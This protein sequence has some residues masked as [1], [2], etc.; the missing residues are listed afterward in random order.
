MKEWH[1]HAKQRDH[2]HMA[3]QAMAVDPPAPVAS[4]LALPAPR[5]VTTPLPIITTI[6]GNGRVITAPAFIPKA[7]PAAIAAKP[8]PKQYTGSEEVRPSIWL[9]AEK[10]RDLADRMEMTLTV[11]M[12]K[13][14]ETHVIDVVQL[15]KDQSLKR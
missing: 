7:L 13:C 2:A 15:P 5:P 11:Q 9:N 10:A 14:L 6:N 8:I 3:E 1:D 12:L 4:T